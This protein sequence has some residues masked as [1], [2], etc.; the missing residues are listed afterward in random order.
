M[1][2]TVLKYSNLLWVLP[3][4][5]EYSA[6]GRG[7]LADARLIALLGQLVPRVDSHF[8]L[9]GKK[10]DFV[11]LLLGQSLGPVVRRMASRYGKDKLE[12]NFCSDLKGAPPELVVAM[13][14]E[15]RSSVATGPLFEFEGALRETDP[16]PSDSV[17][18]SDQSQHFDCCT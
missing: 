1:C 5:P 6:G 3:L 12:N 10:L 18:L 2:V 13:W 7:T 17:S 8:P 15:R 16:G 4:L 9:C 14:V 11:T